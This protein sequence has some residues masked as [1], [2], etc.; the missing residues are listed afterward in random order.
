MGGAAS[1]K[2]MDPDRPFDMDAWVAD[3]ATTNITAKDY[4]EGPGGVSEDCLFLDVRVP[5]KTLKA[6]A[7]GM[8]RA[9]V[10][11]WVCSVI[12]NA[13][14]IHPLLSDIC[15]RLLAD[16]LPSSYRRSMAVAM[17]SAPSSDF[18]ALN[19]SPRVYSP[20]EIRI[21]RV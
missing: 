7:R 1:S 21:R 2:W 4:N 6:A 18:P 16:M 17:I 13:F 11:V 12:P 10:L 20:R 9:P 14:V 5:R 15:P 3:L 19:S 8:K